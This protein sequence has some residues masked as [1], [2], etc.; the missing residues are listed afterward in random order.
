MAV[1]RIPHTSAQLTKRG[2]PYLVRQN[3]GD[4]SEYS[5]QLELRDSFKLKPTYRIFQSSTDTLRRSIFQYLSNDLFEV[6]DLLVD[7]FQRSKSTDPTP[8]SG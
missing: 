6:T 2:V 7:L 5:V 3:P 1:F 4:S 8:L